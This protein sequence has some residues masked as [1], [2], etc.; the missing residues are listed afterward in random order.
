MIDSLTSEERI[1]EV[2]KGGGETRTDYLLW[3]IPR[4]MY[5]N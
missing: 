3:H 2:E 1:E 4:H 5:L